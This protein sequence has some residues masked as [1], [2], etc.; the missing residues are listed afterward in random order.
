MCLPIT[1]WVPANGENSGMAEGLDHIEKVWS[2]PSA[3]F[4][5]A[6]RTGAFALGPDDYRGEQD[7]SQRVA[8]RVLSVVC[9]LAMA[10]MYV[11]ACHRYSGGLPALR[12]PAG[13]AAI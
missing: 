4:F 8:L 2:S 3:I 10:S 9:L 11:V 7:S 1:A 5:T 6:L 12:I 13:V